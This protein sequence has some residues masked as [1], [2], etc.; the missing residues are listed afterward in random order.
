MVFTHLPRLG[1]GSEV[2][3][4]ELGT[5]LAVDRI[6]DPKRNAGVGVACIPSLDPAAEEV[7][8]KAGAVGDG[9]GMSR[10]A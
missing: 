2:L 3:A 6:F 1:T 9:A 7:I 5:L 4:R 8:D 10:L